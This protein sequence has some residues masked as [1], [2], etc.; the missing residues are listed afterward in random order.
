MA[1]GALADALVQLGRFAEARACLR[2]CL[3]L[4]PGD[5]GRRP[6]VTQELR[7]CEQLLAL[8]QRLSAILEG[9]AQP[10]HV[11]ERLLLA[12]FCQLPFKRLYAASARFYAEAFAQDTMLA[13]GTPQPHRYNAACAAALA[14]CGQGRD[15]GALA[16]RD[17]IRLRKQAVAWLRADLAYWSGLARSARPADRAAVRQTLQHWQ[18]DPDLAGLRER[19]ALKK[20]PAE[21]REACAK[22]WAD[23]AE[24]LKKG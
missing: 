21:E 6:L 20:L 3:E 1:H 7:Q 13:T 19:E 17:R 18:A 15:A 8:E 16:E 2:R 11:P 23:V 12:Q 5:D 4:L 10:A 9:K 24:L 22:L 14:G